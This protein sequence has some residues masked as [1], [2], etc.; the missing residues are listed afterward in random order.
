MTDLYILCHSPFLHHMTYI[1]V[2]KVYVKMKGIF[3]LS[4]HS[5]EPPLPQSHTLH[6]TCYKVDFYISL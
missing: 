4:K 5:K 6:R 1:E 3:L 2:I